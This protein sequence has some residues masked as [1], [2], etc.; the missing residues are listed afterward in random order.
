MVALLWWRFNK[1]NENRL[2][3][4]PRRRSFGLKPRARG[5][6]AGVASFALRFSPSFFYANQNT[7]PNGW[8]FFWW[9]FWTKFRF[10]LSKTPLRKPAPPPLASLPHHRKTF[11][12]HFG[13]CA[14]PIFLLKRKRKF[15][16]VSC[17]ELQ[18]GGSGLYLSQEHGGIPPTPFRHVLAGENGS[19]RAKIL[20]PQPLPFCPPA[21]ASPPKLFGDGRRD[22][23]VYS[24]AKFS[25]RKFL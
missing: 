16:V 2:R 25:F 7:H 21:W 24:I 1:L 23:F 22:I 19:R 10:S 12:L 18:G 4:S 5:N 3:L 14:R 17:N 9:C 13:F 11:F 8:V 15:S 6:P 20:P